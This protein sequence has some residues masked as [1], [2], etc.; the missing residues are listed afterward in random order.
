MALPFIQAGRF[1]VVW[2]ERNFKGKKVYVEV[3]DAGELILNKGLASMRYQNKED[4]KIYNASPAN[5]TPLDGAPAS[6]PPPKK[7]A[8][9]KKTSSGG[10]KSASDSISCSDPVNWGPLYSAQEVPD[11]LL[12]Q[13]APEPG[14]IEI[15]TDGACSGNPGPCGYGVILRDGDSYLELS[16]YLGIGTNN[17]GELMAI[18]VAL[19]N[20]ADKTR[21]VR[22]YT[23]ST[24]CIG[25]LTQG[26]K[27]KA[28]QE[29]ILEI[30][31]MLPLF[32]DLKFIKVKGH[33][34]H[35]L[36]ERADT[37]ATSS[38]HRTT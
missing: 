33:A 19:E 3:D 36:N 37:M 9:P 27:A 25:V 13:P 7:A 4:A 20:V 2:S 11:E 21:P 6:A 34:G 8:A 10:T 16:Q 12:S 30:K 29:L 32:T 26:W 15:H 17:I 22:I 1:L 24:Y 35:P 5:L 28:N 23:D 38:L 18:K 31:K 14:T